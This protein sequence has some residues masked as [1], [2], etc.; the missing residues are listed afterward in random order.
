LKKTFILL[1]CCALLTIA[2]SACTTLARGNAPTGPNAVHMDN[3]TF[4]QAAITIKKGEVVTLVND[5]A[6]VHVIANGTW[7]GNTPHPGIE[8]GAPQIN[9]IQI[10]GNDAAKIGPFNTAGTF[11]LYC[12]VHLGMK[13]T[14][15]VQ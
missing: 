10:N 9:N 7:N 11:Q 2:I 12:T 6:V 3:L 13:M 1:L 14:V 15:I 8:Q 5:A 4:K